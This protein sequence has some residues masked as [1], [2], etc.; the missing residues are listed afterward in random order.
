M[1]SGIAR[2]HVTLNL[3]ASAGDSPLGQ[4]TTVERIGRTETGK[5]AALSR[6][7]VDE[8]T[9]GDLGRADRGWDPTADS[10][11]TVVEVACDLDAGD[12]QAGLFECRLLG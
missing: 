12:A 11:T 7:G 8:W 5:Q 10:R 2:G 1:G 6:R 4:R 9:T 3:Q